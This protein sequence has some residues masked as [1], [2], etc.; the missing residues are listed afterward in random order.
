MSKYT[1][2]KSPC[3]RAAIYKFGGKRRQCSLCKK[4][5]TMW[6]KKQ[7]RSPLRPRR[8]LLRK[9]VAEKQSLIGHHRHWRHLTLGAW[10]F[11]LRSTME[12]FLKNNGPNATPS[13][14]LILIID[15]L[16]FWFEKK[17]WTMYLMAVRSVL[18]DQAV[19]LDPALFLGRENYDEWSKV[20][21]NLPK[22]TRNRIKALVCDGFRGT[23]GIARDN[24]WV[25]QRC[26]FHLLS[27]LQVNRGKW[28]QLS[29]SPQR[30]RVYQAVRKTLAVKPENLSRCVKSLSRLLVKNDCPKRL[31]AIGREFL[32]RLDQFRACRN[33]PQLRLPN[34][35]NT[36][37]SLNRIIRSHCKHLRTPKSLNLRAKVLIRMRKTM[38][39][40]PKIFQ[41][42]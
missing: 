15:A 2:E 42:N 24:G 5:W 6:P 20:I 9:I 7:G 16:W 29:D 11:R 21:N 19:I 39:C 1:R 27:Q 35:T 4:T 18:S 26:H 41:Q 17:R 28:K 37:E 14:P 33:Y 32:R 8:T 38:T 13:G 36:I 25:I 34:T 31:G 40:K 30:E 10:S 3:C 23:D 22:Q 12:K